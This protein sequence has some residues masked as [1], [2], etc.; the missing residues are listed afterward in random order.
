MTPLSGRPGQ[1]ASHPYYE[2]A[3]RYPTSWTQRVQSLCDRCGVSGEEGGSLIT[4]R[5]KPAPVNAFV[6]ACDGRC[7]QV[8][9]ARCPSK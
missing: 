8:S 3:A 9:V 7:Q 5:R 6:I 1:A 2:R 4:E